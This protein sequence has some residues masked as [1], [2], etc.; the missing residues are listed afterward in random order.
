MALAVVY[1][2]CERAGVRVGAL[3]G[4][5]N[6]LFEICNSSSWTTLERS[7]FIIDLPQN[8]VQLALESESI[9]ADILFIVACRRIVGSLRAH[10]L[11]EDIETQGYLKFP[12]SLVSRRKSVM[13]VRR[14]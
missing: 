9:S 8:S 3:K 11:T 2:L 12:P 13:G 6:P 1:A 7:R 4:I 10:L 14:S 5:A